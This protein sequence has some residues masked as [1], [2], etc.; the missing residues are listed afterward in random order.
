MTQMAPLLFHVLNDTGVRSWEIETWAPPSWRWRTWKENSKD[1]IQ[2]WGTCN[3]WRISRYNCYRTTSHWKEQ[4]S[5]IGVPNLRSKTYVW[6]TM[7]SVL[8][9]LRFLTYQIGILLSL[10]WIFEIK[11]ENHVTHYLKENR[12]SV[13]GVSWHY[14]FTVLWRQTS[15][16]PDHAHRVQ[17]SVVA[18]FGVCSSWMECLEK[19]SFD[20]M[21]AVPLAK[22]GVA[23]FCIAFTL[24]S[25]TCCRTE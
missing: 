23:N 1:R 7:Y 4:W 9:T 17:T 10:L 6:S 8:L 5:Q 13:K 12:C 19:S 14:D 21:L 25:H 22:R 15:P 3:K 24:P 2:N 11:Y 20:K 18:Q 16:G